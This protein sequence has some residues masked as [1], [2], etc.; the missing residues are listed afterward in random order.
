MNR[1]AR[2]G[3]RIRSRKKGGLAIGYYVSSTIGMLWAEQLFRRTSY[4][5]SISDWEAEVDKQ[6]GLTGSYVTA[7]FLTE[8]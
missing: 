5:D 8:R 1:R 6:G 7:H 2:S 4:A 3:Q